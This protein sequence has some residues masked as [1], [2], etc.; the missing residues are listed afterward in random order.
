MKI[1]VVIPTRDCNK[2]IEHQ[3]EWYNRQTFR[4]FQVIFSDSSTPENKSL[5]RILIKSADFDCKMIDSPR[6][7]WNTPIARNMGIDEANGDIIFLSDADYFPFPDCLERHS[8][9]YDNLNPKLVL[10]IDY[11]FPHDSVSINDFDL[12]KFGQGEYQHIVIWPDLYDMKNCVPSNVSMP[13]NIFKKVRFDEDFA[14][15]H[16]SEDWWFFYQIKFKYPLYPLMV[17]PYPKAAAFNIYEGEYGKVIRDSFPNKKKL[18]WKYIDLYGELSDPD[19][20]YI[21]SILG[22]INTLKKHISEEEGC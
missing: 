17:S 21:K 5:I 3:I 18:L 14:G 1:S 4:N 2:N 15:N 20:N 12:E 8:D 11:F 22:T 13:K 10:G 6:M 16:G 19:K 9:H 7:N